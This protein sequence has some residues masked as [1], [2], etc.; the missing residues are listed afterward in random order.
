METKDRLFKRKFVF[1][2]SKHKRSNDEDADAYKIFSILYGLVIFIGGVAFSI[3][4]AIIPTEEA[5]NIKHLAEIYFTYLYW[6]SIF[7][8]IFCI[9]DIVRHR[10]K[11][12]IDKRTAV[13]LN[14]NNFPLSG[15]NVRVSG[16]KN[17]SPSLYEQVPSIS[18][19]PHFNLQLFDDSDEFQS[20]DN[21]NEIS[22]ERQ[23]KQSTDDDDDDD[24]EEKEEMRHSTHLGRTHFRSQ[25][26]DDLSVKSS[27]GMRRRSTVTR[28]V[29]TR[30]HAL[31]PGDVHNLRSYV[32]HRKNS[33]VQRVIGYNYDDHST[34]GGLY[35]RVGIGIFC[36]GT[37]IHSGL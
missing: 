20:E 30:R 29:T 19:T 31:D 3:S 27:G 7:W 15:G 37:V 8:I 9:I 12:N 18:T 6:V 34:A 21:Q 5:E 24:E 11:F 33:I 17:F 26:L 4:H 2:F 32:R 16:N 13:R 1:K 10:R 14:S 22:K 36:L 28:D 25:S 23:R 35:I